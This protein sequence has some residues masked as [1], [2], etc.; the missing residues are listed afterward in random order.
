MVFGVSGN[1]EVRIIVSWNTTINI[2][3]IKKN[4]V[5]LKINNIFQK[6]I[7]QYCSK[8]DKNGRHS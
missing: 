3:Q 4:A 2:L 6:F 7:F 1:N 5:I 8:F